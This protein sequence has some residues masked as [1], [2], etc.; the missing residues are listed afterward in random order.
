M[1][2]LQAKHT[3]SDYDGHTEFARLTTEQRLMWLSQAAQFVV[4]SRL[5]RGTNN[6]KAVGNRV[7]ESPADYLRYDQLT[8]K[9]PKQ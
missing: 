9:M 1:R 8:R 3:P 4:A 7:A 6:E 2:R 5:A